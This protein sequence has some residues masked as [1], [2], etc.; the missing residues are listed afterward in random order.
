[1]KKSTAVFISIILFGAL[2]IF[3]LN[4][5]KAQIENWPQFRGINCSG[6]AAEGQN[7]PISFGPDKNILWKTSLPEGHSSPCI[8][9]DC[10]FLTG[11]EEEGKLL[12][13]YCIDRNDGMSS[14]VSRSNPRSRMLLYG[15]VVHLMKL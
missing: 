3:I 11:F 4:P 9:G 14:R 10:I 6:L 2:S 5:L 1:M 7:P 15:S 12:I 13:M 8:W